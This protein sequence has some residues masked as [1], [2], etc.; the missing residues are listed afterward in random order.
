[1][2]RDWKHNVFFYLKIKK[3]LWYKLSGRKCGI[4][5]WILPWN[6]NWYIL[7]NSALFGML[8]RLQIDISNRTSSKALFGKESCQRSWLRDF[9]TFC[10][11]MI[12]SWKSPYRTKVNPSGFSYEKPPPCTQGRLCCGF[13]GLLFV[14][15][16]WCK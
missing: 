14:A 12:F 8:V 16:I 5:F 13:L 9:K 1:M 15:E 6:S 2:W 10:L 7:Q 11:H 4:Y 3:D